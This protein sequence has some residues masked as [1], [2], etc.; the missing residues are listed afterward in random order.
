MRLLGKL[1]RRYLRLYI[2]KYDLQGIGLNTFRVKLSF[3]SLLEIIH[4]NSPQDT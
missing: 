2:E 4:K 1:L 3:H